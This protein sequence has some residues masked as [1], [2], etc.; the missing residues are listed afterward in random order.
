MDEKGKYLLEFSKKSGGDKEEQIIL[1]SRT[2]TGFKELT[3]L[4]FRSRNSGDRY[5]L[6]VDFL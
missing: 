4:L 5:S 6:R 2:K 1:A 3:I